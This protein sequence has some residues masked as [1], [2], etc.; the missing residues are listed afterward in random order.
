MIWDNTVRC[1]RFRVVV[2]VES[3]GSWRTA[4]LIPDFALSSLSCPS[5]GNCTAV[6]N[7][8]IGSSADVPEAFMMSES[9]GAWGTAR[10]LPG[11]PKDPPTGGPSA[12]WVSCASAGNC[13]VVAEYGTESFVLDETGGSWD[14]A[15]EISGTVSGND[16]GT[17]TAVSCASAGSCATGGTDN[18]QAFVMD[19]TPK[20]ST[21]TVLS[22]SA[23]K[24]TYGK[25]QAERVS[26]TV[27]AT[28]G[29][30]P[31]G[32]V[33]VKAGTAV[34]CGNLTLAASRATCTVATTKLPAGTWHLTASYSGSASLAPSTAAA[35]TLTVAKAASR[36][37]LS[38][39]AAR[40]TY[41]Q[42]RSE[43]LTVKVTGQYAG[44]PA[45]KVTVKSGTT[46]VCTITLASGKGSCT[47]AAKKLP[48]GTSTL[49]A[50]YGGSSDFAGAASG[51]KT[52][53]VVK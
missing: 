27:S 22:L 16:L 52:L 31:S 3:G 30:T 43:R 51:T 4:R 48:V 32:T 18:G 8:W 44:T 20:P 42:E 7:T 5:P 26:V 37:T 33:T 15:Q 50:V 1:G 41:G 25:E 10:V 36:V 9:G 23:A 34:L 40:V 12:D 29:A 24:V 19:E 21:S 38:L 14:K 13:A 49:V 6:G 2:A 46:T 53:K 17:G 11:A 47:M 35:K 45:G 39:S 28:T